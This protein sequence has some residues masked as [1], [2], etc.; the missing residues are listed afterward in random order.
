[1]NVM[2]KIM[3]I[4]KILLMVVMPDGVTGAGVISK[5]DNEIVS[6]VFTVRAFVMLLYLKIISNMKTLL[7]NESYIYYSNIEKI[8]KINALV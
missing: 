1:M 2:K 4:Y 7:Y 6:V 3:A 5:K 8:D